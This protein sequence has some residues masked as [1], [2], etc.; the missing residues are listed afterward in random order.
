MFPFF[1]P[2]HVIAC[3]SLIMSRNFFLPIFFVFV[4]AHGFPIVCF[5]SLVFFSSFFFLFFNIKSYFLIFFSYHNNN[6]NKTRPFLLLYRFVDIEVSS[7]PDVFLYLTTDPDD[8]DD[9]DATGS[10][11]VIVEGAERGTFS[12][13]GNFSQTVP[14]GFTTPEDYVAAVV[15]CDQFSVFFGSG[16]FEDV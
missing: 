9:V 12:F 4:E 13:T 14:D 2:F 1:I 15:W 10:L 11:T 5:L 7:G 16:L 3:L 6:D 8:P